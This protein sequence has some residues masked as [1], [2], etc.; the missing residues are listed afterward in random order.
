MSA[1]E[2]EFWLFRDF[3]VVYI[4]MINTV[5]VFWYLRIMRITI[6][7][8]VFVCMEAFC[9]VVQESSDRKY[10]ELEKDTNQDTAKGNYSGHVGCF[11]LGATTSTYII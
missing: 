2:P 6:E 3:L 8:E 4:E 9:F 11:Y 5:A 10:P 1:N 7:W